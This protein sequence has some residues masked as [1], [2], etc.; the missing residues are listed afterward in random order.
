MSG[1]LEPE[2]ALWA[3][4]VIASIT[5]LIWGKIYNAL[6]FAFL[7]TG[8]LCRF[9]FSGMAGGTE[10]C[11][12]VAL[13]FAL[14]FPLWRLKAMAAGD[15]KLL[16]AAGAWSSPAEILR[17]AACAVVIGA[18]VGG[19][20]LVRRSGLKRGL[21]SVREHLRAMSPSHS[22]RIPFAPA[23]LCALFLVRIGEMYRWTWL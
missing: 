1:G 17:L 19:V 6:T 5:D 12:A 13:A 11:C 15:V 14:F 20:L 21:S 4:L 18:L 23:F 3:L 2:I 9:A 16:M 8:L 7:G 22:H 10:A